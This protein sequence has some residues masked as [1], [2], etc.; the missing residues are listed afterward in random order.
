MPKTEYILDL[1]PSEELVIIDTDYIE[2]SANEQKEIEFQ[3]TAPES[4]ELG[5]YYN[6]IVFEPRDKEESNEPVIGA[7][8]AISHLVKV[9]ISTNILGT[10]VTDDFDTSLEVVD[11][12]IP[13]IRPAKIKFTFFNNSEYTLIPKGEIQVVKHSGDREP[14]YFKINVP[15]DRVFPKESYEEEF[16]VDKWFIE[17]IIFG[18]T[19]FI[20]I[21]NGIDKNQRVEEIII[22]GFRNEFLYIL[23]TTTVIILL[24]SSLRGDT[25]PE[26]EYAE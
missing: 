19:A 15:R 9:N 22:P 7:S 26:P 16:E 8:G 3:V 11:R 23:A 12:G 20:R 17:D 1:E 25:K 24:A 6:L 14:Q 5:T 10:Q 18:K 13:F 4:L 2:I 21:E